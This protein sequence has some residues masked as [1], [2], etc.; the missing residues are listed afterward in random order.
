M[1]EAHPGRGKAQHK[2]TET[3]V[4]SAGGRGWSWP[5]MGHGPLVRAGL[6]GPPK[7]FGFYC[8]PKMLVPLY[9]A[10]LARSVEEGKWRR[11]GV[12]GWLGA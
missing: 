1:A 11:V 12:A 9:W 3:G 10:H 6:A 5:S 8:G 2:G 7:D 4:V